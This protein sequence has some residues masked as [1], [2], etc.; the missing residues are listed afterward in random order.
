M[1]LAHA[2]RDYQEIKRLE[3]G[4]KC[5][6]TPAFAPGRI[7]IRGQRHLYSIGERP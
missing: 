7:V 4:E 3:L 1:I 5:F 6:A 2:G